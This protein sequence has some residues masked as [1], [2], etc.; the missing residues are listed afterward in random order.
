MK[1]IL[2]ASVALL[3]APTG[4]SAAETMR[5]EHFAPVPCTVS[6]GYFLDAVGA[7]PCA[8]PFP[9]G[10]YD[11]TIMQMTAQTGIVHI[12]AR[13]TIDYDTFVCSL[14]GEQLLQGDH[15]GQDCTHDEGPVALGCLEFYD[16]S[17]NALTA[18]G[19]DSGRFM[20]VS[21]NW[22][23]IAALPITVTGPAEIVDDTY[24]ARLI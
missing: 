16:I 22:L 6:C 8:T 1:R 12:E 9:K 18:T 17:W 24:D 5:I 4:S 13:P 20:I 15:I 14:H 19:D 11:F 21:Y 2:L 3:L 7:G 23:D 10:S